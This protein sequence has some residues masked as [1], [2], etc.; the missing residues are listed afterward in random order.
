MSLSY[1]F[2][3]DE[4][5]LL[6]SWSG[7][8]SDT[9]L[10]RFYMSIYNS[11]QWNSKFNEVIDLR[12][13]QLETIS[14]KALLQLSELATSCLNGDQLKLVMIAPSELSPQI[15]RIYKAFSYIPNESTKVVHHLDEAVDWLT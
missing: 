8:I 6:T 7:E 1:R 11:N 15:A 12:N 13:A 4:K 10:V 5:I 14:D 3:N 9:E 2:Y